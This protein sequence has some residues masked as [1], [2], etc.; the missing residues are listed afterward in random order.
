ML[1][2]KPAS[3]SVLWGVGQGWH[4][5]KQSQAQLTN[6][7]SFDPFPLLPQINIDEAVVLNC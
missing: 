7:H 6:I 4:Q 5:E 1:I 2:E 3:L